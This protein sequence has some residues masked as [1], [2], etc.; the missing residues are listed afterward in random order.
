MLATSTENPAAPADSCVE[1]IE[2][3]REPAPLGAEEP[4]PNKQT[5]MVLVQSGSR[6]ILGIP[7]PPGRHRHLAEE[8]MVGI[9]QVPT[10]THH[11]Q[12]APHGGVARRFV[13]LEAA[14][15]A[16]PPVDAVQELAGLHELLDHPALAH[17]QA[18]G[19]KRHLDRLPAGQ[20]FGFDVDRSAARILLRVEKRLEAE[21]LPTKGVSQLPSFDGTIVTDFDIMKHGHRTGTITRRRARRAD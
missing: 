1:L 15:V 4:L 16:L 19:M 2:E 13:D 10:A 8:E 12:Q 20:P 7:L 21:G 18:L 14:L 17:G 6:E 11:A 5:T 3:R 9:E